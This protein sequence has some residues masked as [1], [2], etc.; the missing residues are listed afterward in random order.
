MI[1]FGS[2]KF[3]HGNIKATLVDRYRGYQIYQVDEHIMT[4][5]V[6]VTGN[7]MGD[8]V[9]D[10]DYIEEFFDPRK[11][12]IILDAIK[13]LLFKKGEDVNQYYK[14]IDDIFNIKY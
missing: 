7:Q 12:G 11:K 9:T 5:R 3:T 14:N 13:V 2:V 4:N 1:K 10:E 8:M 6:F